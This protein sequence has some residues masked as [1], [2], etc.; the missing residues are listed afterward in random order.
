MAIALPHSYSILDQSYT[1]SY[2]SLRLDEDKQFYRQLP[3][4][5]VEQG[6]VFI[7]QKYDVD[8]QYRGEQIEYRASIQ[9][10]REPSPSQWYDFTLFYAWNVADIKVNGN[11]VAW[12]R[13]GDWMRIYFPASAS[14]AYDEIS[15]RVHGHGRAKSLVTDNSFYLAET[16]PW[17]PVPG[18][19]TVATV[20]PYYY[21][22]QYTRILLPEE[23]QYTVHI[24][25]APRYPVYSNLARTGTDTF[26][27][28]AQGVMLASSLLLEAGD[29]HCH[30]YMMSKGHS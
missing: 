26:G 11:S 27:G 3:T 23:A 29:Q 13:S 7:A 18:R 14:I 1:S 15:M 21:E 2:S 10:K 8:L 30:K 19:H 16:F 25:S 5:R 22:P 20:S 4:Q 17:L 9:V 12:E 24:S 6:P 28:R